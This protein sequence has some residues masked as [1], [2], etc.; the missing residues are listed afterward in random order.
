MRTKCFECLE[1]E[2]N[3]HKKE[4]I[5]IVGCAPYIG[6]QV[7]KRIMTEEQMRLLIYQVIDT[8]F[9]PPTEMTYEQ[10][11]K[12][13]EEYKLYGDL[14]NILQKLADHYEANYPIK[15]WNH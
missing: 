4:T 14:H 1:G 7:Q 3:K 8:M 2:A 6:K 12:E 9:S 15:V 10:G 13:R 5:P 11:N